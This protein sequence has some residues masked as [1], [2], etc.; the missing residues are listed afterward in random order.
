MQQIEESATKAVSDLTF[1]KAS[2]GNAKVTVYDSRGNRMTSAQ[3]RMNGFNPNSLPTPMYNG[4]AME[5]LKYGEIDI[6]NNAGNLAS[7]QQ[8]QPVIKVPIT[9]GNDKNFV[10]QNTIG[11]VF[12]VPVGTEGQYAV[13]EYDMPLEHV[14]WDSYN[15]R[16]LG[17]STT[18]NTFGTKNMLDTGIRGFEVITGQ[19]NQKEK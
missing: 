15:K 9:N 13:I 16:N 12:T 4:K 6:Q 7:I 2:P 3:K 14:G 17:G 1:L 5:G 8:K 19:N 10:K 11:T 18:S